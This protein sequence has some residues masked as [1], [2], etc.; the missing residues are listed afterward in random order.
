[1]CVLFTRVHSNLPILLATALSDLLTSTDLG[2]SLGYG[3][4]SPDYLGIL[5]LGVVWHL[6]FRS[7]F[8]LVVLSAYGEV[9]IL[10][11]CSIIV[12][13]KLTTQMR[14]RFSSVFV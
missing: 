4:E 2:S 12:S 10:P 7:W 11:A 9:F 5:H 8:D 3:F 6:R 13:A 1:M 14:R